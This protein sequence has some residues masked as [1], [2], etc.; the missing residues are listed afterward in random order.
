VSECLPSSRFARQG[1]LTDVKPNVHKCTNRVWIGAPDLRAAILLA[2]YSFIHGS[3]VATGR[4]GAVS[5]TESNLIFWDFMGL[6]DREAARF[7]ASKTSSSVE[8]NP[9]LRRMPDLI[10]EVSVP[11]EW[12]Y[13]RDSAYVAW[14]RSH[15]TFDTLFKQGKFGT[16]DLWRRKS[17]TNVL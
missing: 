10:L 1:S 14:L 16:L 4:I 12:S 9:V 17:M 7:L 5:Y 13:T 2:A 15:Y 11:V 8:A 3:T 6:T